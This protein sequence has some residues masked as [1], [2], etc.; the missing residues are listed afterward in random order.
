MEKQS[1]RKFLKLIVA[2]V[3]L[4]L[5]GASAL[6]LASC[7]KDEHQ[8]SY[9][10]SVTT[11][12]TCSNPG[13]ETFTCSCGA[14]Y[15]QIIPATND[16]AWEK[17]KVYA[18]S[19]ESE[20]WTVYECSVCHEQK[21][22][23][24]T[25]KL[26]HKYEAVETVE[27]TC[28]TDGYQIMQCSYCGDRYTDDQYSSE[29]KAT[30]HKW[31]ANTDAEDPASAEDKKLGFVTVKEADCLNAAQLER[32]C[33]VCGE[34]EEKEGAPA[35]GHLWNDAVVTSKTANLCKVNPS[36]ID[37]EGNAIY[38]Y[39]CER[40]NCPVEVVIDSADHTRHYIKAEEHKLKVVHEDTFCLDEDATVDKTQISLPDGTN[41]QG[42]GKR[43]EICENCDTYGTKYDESAES[44][45]KVTDLEPTGHNWNTIQLDGKTPVVVCEADAKLTKDAY[46]DAMKKALGTTAYAPLAGAFAQAYTDKEYSRYCSDCGALQI[47]GG[48]DYVIAALEEGKYD[49]DD[50][51]KDENGL[52]VVAEGVTVATMDC[53]YVQ[54]CA[55]EGCG[56]VLERG[57]HGEVSTATCRKGGFCELCGEQFTA[58]LE[59]NYINIASLVDES[60]KVKDG[61][62][63]IGTTYK[64]AY[65]AYVKVSATETWMKPVSGNCEDQKTNVYV[66]LNCLMT[67]ADEKSE[68]EVVWNQ[69]TELP[70]TATENGPVAAVS[71][72]NAYVIDAGLGHDYQPTYYRLSD[73]TEIPYTQTTCAVGFLVKY[74]CDVC[75]E[76]YTNVPVANDPDTKPEKGD[77]KDDS[78]TNEAAVNDPGTLGFT[79]ADGFVLDVNGAGL[80]V[81]ITSVDFQADEL[82]DVLASKE[83]N[84]GRH[85]VQVA[86][87]YADRNGYVASTCVST[88]IIPVVCENCG[89]AL[90]Y[91]YTDLAAASNKDDTLATDYK[92]DF[93]IN[94]AIIDAEKKTEYAI[95]QD[96]ET[97]SADTKL[98]YLNHAEGAKIFDC[99]THCDASEMVNGVKTYICSGY[100]ADHNEKANI[101]A[102]TANF[103]N[104]FNEDFHS[105]V[106]VSYK[107]ATASNYYSDYTIRVATIA[108][109]VTDAD[110]IDWTKV[111]FTTDTK[112]SVCATN[113]FASLGSNTTY[114]MPKVASELSNGGTFFV[115]TDSEGTNY[116]VNTFSL[117]TEDKGSAEA[118]TPVENGQNVAQDDDFFLDVSSSKAPV[119]AT[120]VAS[121]AKAVS[122]AE[123]D[124]GVLTITL[125]KDVTFETIGRLNSTDEDMKALVSAVK[126]KLAAVSTSLKSVVLDLNG[127]TIPVAA[128]PTVPKTNGYTLT[129]KNGTINYSTVEDAEDYFFTVN[130]GANATFENVTINSGKL[131]AISV[132]YEADATTKFTLKN[133]TV[134]SYGNVGISVDQSDAT[135]VEAGKMATAITLTDTDIV[136]AKAPTALPTDAPAMS[137]AMLVGAPVN[138]SVKG[139]EFSATMQALVVRGGNVTVST[140][141]LTV[142]AYT[143]TRVVYTGTAPTL[144]EGQTATSWDSLGGD[145]TATTGAL[146]GT[147][148]EGFVDGITDVQ[149]YR[150]AGVWGEGAA[151]ARAAVVLGNSDT[152]AYKFEATLRLDRVSWSVAEGAEKV[153]VGTSYVSDMLKPTY[154]ADDKEEENPIYT[155]V[156]TLNATGSNL[157]VADVVYTYISY[158]DEGKLANANYISMIGLIPA[159]D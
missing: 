106:T 124:K 64:A 152:T 100:D 9:T 5:L 84:Q 114:T 19:C 92:F 101:T 107:L 57:A 66:C 128:D 88:A 48:H 144:P 117:Y 108:A 96:I 148:W 86:S 70:A 44:V 149:T 122:V 34:T 18:N 136:M 126:A 55:N 125:A 142:N 105:T 159:A 39:E 35:L 13:V 69:A 62:I 4:F 60:G 65:D 33:S 90:S 155:P 89:A 80:K 151:V 46:L 131:N 98:N 15:T 104:M 110:K 120:D 7:N 119:H 12:A 63:V 109:G 26:D 87:K 91:T 28:T 40:E 113:N 77:E 47:A 43:Y 24:W 85:S 83:D 10:G 134:I 141:K 25:P 78:E 51:E 145:T 27:A 45:N 38:A 67:A 71:S 154:D 102:T 95:S 50:Y 29:H 146:I 150:L 52:P 81:G 58:Q 56:K 22:D 147:A 53:R 132:E 68:E 59:H 23:D 31:I 158:N 17:I 41:A 121:L 97:G 76:V 1:T 133:S 116:L 37:A 73:K 20:G 103:A 49:L 118:M 3:A 21:Q 140:T 139:G 30:G 16:H 153:V 82:A 129:V 138:V 157:N 42:A 54:V 61:E 112:L 135:A 143:D 32:K 130:A 123:V 127:S 115:L 36:L 72:T 14:A 137:T 2:L 75:G 6:M 79:D 94:N 93:V 99:G 8:H 74:T 156:V 11:P 111:T